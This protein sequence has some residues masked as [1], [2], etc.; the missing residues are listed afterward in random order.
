MVQRNK[1]SRLQPSEHDG[2]A[3][4]EEQTPAS[5]KNKFENKIFRGTKRPGYQPETASAALMKYLVESDKE[6]QTEPP[7]DPTDAF[8]KSI[9]ATLKKF[10][11]VY[12]NICKSRIFAIVSKVEM[13]DIL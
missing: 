11:P 5:A 4:Q 1:R 13:T 8:F 6:R 9:A 3:E 10:P 7:V 2:T 12:Q